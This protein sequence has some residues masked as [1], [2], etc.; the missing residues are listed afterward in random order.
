MH[1]MLGCLVTG[2]EFSTFRIYANDT[3]SYSLMSPR[4]CCIRSIHSIGVRIGFRKICMLF[5]ASLY[6]VLFIRYLDFVRPLSHGCCSCNVDIQSPASL[7]SKMA[8][9][10]LVNTKRSFDKQLKYSIKQSKR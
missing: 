2:H 9:L 5:F 10:T 4:S 6:L 8:F 3:G 1:V 7:G